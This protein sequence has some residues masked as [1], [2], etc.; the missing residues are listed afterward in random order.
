MRVSGLTTGVFVGD[1]KITSTTALADNS[2]FGSSRCNPFITP[3]G[4]VVFDANDFDTFRS[5]GTSIVR[6]V[7]SGDPAPGGGTLSPVENR[8]SQMTMATSLLPRLSATLQP[9]KESSEATV[10]RRSPSPAMI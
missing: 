8:A 2:S 5:N 7:G 10:Q 6:L 1:G 3:N 9:R 4:D